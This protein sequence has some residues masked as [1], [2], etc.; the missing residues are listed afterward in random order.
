MI[1]NALLDADD[2]EEDAAAV[3]EVTPAND[4]DDVSAKADNVEEVRSLRDR[5]RCIEVSSAGITPP[6]VSL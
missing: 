2:D 1:C 3:L 4:A 6:S 5:L